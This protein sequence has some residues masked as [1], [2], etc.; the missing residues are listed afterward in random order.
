MNEQYAEVSYYYT[1]YATPIG[2]GTLVCNEASLVGL[3][4]EG[5]KYFGDTF[6]QQAIRDND[7]PVLREAKEWLERMVV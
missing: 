2:K 4:I 1:E 5:Q 7:Y 6:L 3:W